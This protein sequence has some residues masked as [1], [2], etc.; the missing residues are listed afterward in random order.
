[1][2]K[3]DY[4]IFGLLVSLFITGCSQQAIKSNDDR[5]YFSHSS[6]KVTT[7]VPPVQDAKIELPIIYFANDSY[8][9]TPTERAKLKQF[10]ETL[11][12]KRPS[13]ILHG[14][15]DWNRS[16]EYNDQLGQHRSEAVLL[17]LV[18]IGY[19]AE[20]LATASLGESQPIADNHT[21]QGRQLNR[22]V[23]LSLF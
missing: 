5:I 2:K 1:M 15:T 19:P 16:D 14:H 23:T 20:K 11:G 7:P 9:V 13:I 4:R 8:E 18:N 12:E 17:S 22:R 10:V 3:S 6:P 21:A